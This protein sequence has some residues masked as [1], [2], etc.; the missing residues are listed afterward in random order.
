MHPLLVHSSSENFTSTPRLAFNV[1]IKWTEDLDFAALGAADEY[2]V[3]E[4]AMVAAASQGVPPRPLLRWFVV[5]VVLMLAAAGV[6]VHLIVRFL[7]RNAA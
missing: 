5:A 4:E 1:Q 2:S 6:S 3:T 7:T